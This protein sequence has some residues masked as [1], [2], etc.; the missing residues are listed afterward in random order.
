MK[1]LIVFVIALG[2]GALVCAWLLARKGARTRIQ[3][4]LWQP[5]YNRASG[6]YDLLDSL[7]L[8]WLPRL[9]RPALDALPAPPARV[10]EVGI[11]SGRLHV[12]LAEHYDA[13]GLD[14]APG[15]VD[16][17]RRRLAKRGLVSDLR[18]GSVTAIP[19]PDATFDAV[20]STFASSAFPDAQ[21]AVSEMARVLKPGGKVIIVDAG[22]A[23]DGNRIAWL[24]ARAWEAIGDYMRDE[25]PYMQAAGLVDITRRDYGP[26][27]CVHITVGAK[28]GRL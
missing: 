6:L 25:R 13:A 28:P 9:R 2:V 15:M 19:W 10:L 16:Y 26:W 20:V 22:D 21:A 8:G 7:T 27:N 5:F 11:G 17:T 1:K 4:H 23:L 12:Q 18:Q 3:R 24:L 14:L